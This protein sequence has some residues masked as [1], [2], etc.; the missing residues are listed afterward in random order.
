MAT[1]RPFA[2]TLAQF[3]TVYLPVTRACS[4]HTVSA[5]RDAFTLFLR[6]MDQQKATPP[7]KVSFADFTASNV[8]AFLGWLCTDRRCSTATANQRLAALKSFFRYVQSQAPEQVAQA[9]QVLGVKAALAPEPAIGYLP[10]EAVGLLLEHAARRRGSRDLA[11]L[12]TLYDTGARVQEA[13]DLT[14][15][16]LHLE[17][18]ASATLTGKGR[19]TRIVPLTPQAAQILTQHL[20]SLP[21]DLTGPTPVFVNS[22]GEQLGRAG[23]AYILARCA[24]AAHAERPELVPENVSPHM[25]RHSKAMHLLENGVNLIYIRD[26]LGHASIVTTEVYAKA[27]P[28]MKR[29]AI[30]AAAVRTLGPSR[31]DQATRQDL[32]TWLRQMI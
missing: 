31:Y 19:K 5:Y 13:C 25:L 11:L 23:A 1:A 20:H 2:D 14:V 3:L 26:I 9:R 7:D 17:K 21:Q 27:N 32:L 10:V 16:D 28:E 29:R 30:E 8:M 24:H 18:P 22:A 4:R 15:R 6:F 12:T